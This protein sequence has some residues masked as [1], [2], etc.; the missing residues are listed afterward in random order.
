MEC[1]GGENL[2]NSGIQSL[3]GEKRGILLIT[4]HFSGI[5]SSERDKRGILLI[6]SGNGG[7]L[8]ITGR[9]SS[10]RKKEEGSPQNVKKL[11]PRIPLLQMC[12]GHALHQVNLKLPQSVLS[13]LCCCLQVS[14]LPAV[15]QR[16][17]TFKI[18][19]LLPC[20]YCTL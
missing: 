2:R 15:D 13:H 18:S 7:I 20:S 6:T 4:G 17:C 12:G 9:D 19:K 5:S 3:E 16:M 1:Q 11:S 8:L 10:R 14:Q